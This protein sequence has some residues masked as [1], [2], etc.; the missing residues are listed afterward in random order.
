MTAQVQ[1]VNPSTNK[2]L[3]KDMWAIKEAFMGTPQIGKRPTHKE[4]AI[5]WEFMSSQAQGSRLSFRYC[6][7]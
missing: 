2:Q 4:H 5:V 6:L 1:V 3:T 7:K